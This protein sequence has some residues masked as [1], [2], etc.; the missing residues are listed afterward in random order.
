[1]SGVLLLPPSG[2]FFGTHAIH[3]IKKKREKENI[4]RVMCIS[5]LFLKREKLKILRERESLKITT[6]KFSLKK[7][8]HYGRQGR[9]ELKK[10]HI[11]KKILL[12]CELCS[13]NLLMK[14]IPQ[15]YF[16][17][18]IPFLY[19]AGFWNGNKWY[20]LGPFSGW[21]AHAGI[22]DHASWRKRF[23][24]VSNSW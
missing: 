2:P 4:E 21:K 6:I 10:I 12:K 22:K 1:M 7:T 11:L 13:P 18:H 20:V 24:G 14:A 9:Y 17:C 19:Q 15:P 16:K 23:E 5:C 8:S 3:Q